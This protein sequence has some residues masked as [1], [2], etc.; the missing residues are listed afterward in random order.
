VRWRLAFRIAAIPLPPSLLS[1]LWQILLF[2]LFSCKKKRHFPYWVSM[3][4]FHQKLL[5]I[6]VLQRR[7]WS[8]ILHPWNCPSCQ[9]FWKNTSFY[10][11]Y[12]GDNNLQTPA[13]RWVL[14]ASILAITTS[15]LQPSV[16]SCRK[17]SFFDTMRICC[18]FLSQ[19][20]AC[21]GYPPLIWTTPCQ[22]WCHQE[23][24]NRNICSELQL[25]SRG[26]H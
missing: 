21:S 24:S 3:G 2:L 8:D 9:L 11:Q 19:L 26:C 6:H 18:C 10:G 15:R 14:H 13:V 7:R 4:G 12:F 25:T 20:Q 22:R 17:G 1:W 23:D 16:V 5:P